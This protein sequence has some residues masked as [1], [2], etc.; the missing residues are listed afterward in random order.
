MQ[1]KI[2]KKNDLYLITFKNNEPVIEKVQLWNSSTR[3]FGEPLAETKA[4]VKFFVKNQ[5]H[6]FIGKCPEGCQAG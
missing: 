2:W 6:I 5:V 4:V 3:V 1:R